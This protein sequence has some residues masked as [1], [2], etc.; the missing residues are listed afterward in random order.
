MDIYNLTANQLKRAAV[1]KEQIA[2]LTKELRAIFGAPARSR[3][4]RKRKR[5]LSVAAKKKIAAAQRARWA[6]IRRTKP[7]KQSVK[8]TAKAK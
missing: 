1:I 4:R 8:T 5:T 3:P 2:D 7:G 6:S